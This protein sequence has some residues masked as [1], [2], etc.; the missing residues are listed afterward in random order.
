MLY[1]FDSFLVVA[2][3]N[4]NKLG[5]SVH[6]PTATSRGFIRVIS[7]AMCGIV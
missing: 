2:L 6:L 5:V 3:F 1:M 7:G 4:R